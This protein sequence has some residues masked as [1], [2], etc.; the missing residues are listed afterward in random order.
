MMI[1]KRISKLR[2]NLQKAVELELSTIPPYLL[3]MWSIKPETNIASSVILRSVLMEEMLHLTLAAN[4]LSAVGGT[5]RL[6][7]ENI[8]SYPLRLE[9]KGK[10]DR[11]I[12]IH[13]SRFSKSAVET[14]LQ[15]EL[16]DNFSPRLAAKA[17]PEIEIPG[18]TIGDFYREIKH[19]LTALCKEHGQK[20]IFT[21]N[22]AHQ[23]S[24]QYFW[25]GGGK[26]V[27]VTD[28]SSATKAIDVIADQGE[29]AD[30][31]LFDGDKHFFGQPEELAH[32]FRFNQ[33][34]NE[35]YYK[36]TDRIHDKPSGEKF[37]VLYADVYPLKA[38]P[39]SV[40]Y[41]S[42]PELRALNNRFNAGYT[43]MLR[44]LAEGFGGN[45]AVFYTAIMNDMLGLTAVAQKMAQTPIKGDPEKQT[46]APTFE[47]RV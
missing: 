6:G 36:K 16:P 30:G 22:A 20:A 35:R 31:S 8:P 23:V 24:E 2:D 4:V 21:G 5:V 25:R 7:K 3:A 44:Q 40:D 9:F 10:R 37:S 13:L 15:I 43:M 28:I 42:D 1:E 45:P 26:P 19:D 33:I 46:G 17:K 34:Y 29:G 32:Y 27:V 18:F 11:E 12:D 14:F 39:K 41:N 47:W 38:D